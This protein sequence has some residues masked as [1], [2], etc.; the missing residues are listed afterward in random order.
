MAKSVK[1]TAG[2]TIKAEDHNNLVDDVVAVETA[3]G[4]KAN[5]SS[6]ASK[7]DK[8]VVEALEA[9]IEA[10]EAAAEPADE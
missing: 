5:S 2:D 10:L 7:A 3:L 6:L 9:R 1:V 8:S 4:T